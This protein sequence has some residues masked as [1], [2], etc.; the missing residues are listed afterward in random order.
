VVDRSRN[1][2]WRGKS[3]LWDVAD[4]ISDEGEEIAD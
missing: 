3:S 1:G 4:W 2:S